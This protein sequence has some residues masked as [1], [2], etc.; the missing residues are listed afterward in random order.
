[1]MKLKL[2][3]LILIF[4]FLASN[5]AF[6]SC[7]KEDVNEENEITP[8]ITLDK[9]ELTLEIGSS[10]RLV[11]SFEPAD[12]LNK[13][14]VWSSSASDV[15]SVDETG[16]VKAVSLGE[17]VITAKALDGGATASCKVVVS[18]KVV[19][20]SGLLLNYYEKTLVV[21]EELQLKGSV[22]PSNA[23]DKKVSWKTSD[24]S[25][26]TVDENGLVTAL[27]A[28]DA[29]VIATTNDGNFSK[30]CS[31]KIIDE[32]A[33]MTK[34]KFSPTDI[35]KDKIIF[36]SP[37]EGELLEDV[38][39][40]FGTNPQPNVM[41]DNIAVAELKNGKLMLT[42]E[43]LEE[44]TKYYLRSYKRNGSSVVYND[45]EV[46]AQTIGD[47]FTVKETYLSKEKYEIIFGFERYYAYLRID[48]NINMEGQF[49]V[50]AEGE[51]SV[52]STKFSR[53]KTNYV[54]EIYVEN[55]EGS[56]NCRREDGN[57]AYEGRYK[58]LAFPVENLVFTNLETSVRYHFPSLQSV[59]YVI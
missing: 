36:V 20:V 12:Y 33:V 26:V 30:S 57:I 54:E 52:I 22:T 10:E 21:G 1:M 13:A 8:V 3:Y 55:G 49:L 31:F 47:N 37:L 51:Y 53:D 59:F 35:Y 39:I 6:I 2:S 29:V 16:L 56:F 7:S 27:S 43:G 42:L 28:G 19:H 4:C 23:T 9:Q 18:A 32:S 24:S 14:H 45:D 25:V 48:Y 38:N 34:T 44:G 41:S 50:T 17:A 5:M 58:Y 46:S 11:A 40:C 15:A